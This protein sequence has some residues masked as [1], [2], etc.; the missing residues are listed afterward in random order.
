MH[1]RC[2]MKMISM[3]SSAD[4]ISAQVEKD[5]AMDRSDQCEQLAKA[6]KVFEN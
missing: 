3:V 6:A 2:R 5:N 4:L 1:M